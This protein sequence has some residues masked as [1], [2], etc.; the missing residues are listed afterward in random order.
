M[1]LLTTVNSKPIDLEDPLIK[2]RILANIRNRDS[3][4]KNLDNSKFKP[5]QTELKQV[6]NPETPGYIKLVPD[7]NGVPDKISLPKYQDSDVDKKNVLD[8]SKTIEKLDQRLSSL[9][10]YLN[11]HG[12]DLPQAYIPETNTEFS[13]KTQNPKPKIS[14]SQK[15]K[16]EGQSHSLFN[17]KLVN[18]KNFPKFTNAIDL[19]KAAEAW[20]QAGVPKEILNPVA[21]SLVEKYQKMAKSAGAGTSQVGNLASS[22]NLKTIPARVST[23]LISYVQPS[24][25]NAGVYPVSGVPAYYSPYASQPVATGLQYVASSLPMWN[26]LE[27]LKNHILNNAGQNLKTQNQNLDNK[28]LTELEKFSQDLAKLKQQI[29]KIDNSVSATQNKLD[30]SHRHIG[31]L[32]SNFDSLQTTQTKV[33][34]DIEFIQKLLSNKLL[35]NDMNDDTEHS[36]YGTSVVNS[37]INNLIRNYVLDSSNGDLVQPSKDGFKSQLLQ[38]LEEQEKNEG[39][40][41]KYHQDFLA[42]QAGDVLP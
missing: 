15:T 38:D 19:R 18:A 36:S 1:L 13:Q 9:V 42:A 31:V 28:I 22:T 26:R 39:V 29:Y 17:E 40:T 27:F 25:V 24:Y 41:L 14:A 10:K 35:D 12:S 33:V 37:M 11:K 16:S 32:S 21:L 5:K 6:E 34:N 30:T 7:N 23:G 2:E 4:Y 8:E 3:F 20:L